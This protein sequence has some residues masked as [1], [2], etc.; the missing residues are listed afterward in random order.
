MASTTNYYA[1]KYLVSRYPEA[2]KILAEGDSWFAYPRRFIAVGSESNVIDH[3]GK[4]N[5]YVIYKTASCG[6]EALAM[7][8]GK[9]KLSLM[10]RISQTDFDFILFSGGGNDVVGRYDFDYF[11]DEK[12]QGMCAHDCISR[13]RLDR[14]LALIAA[15]YEELVDRVAV[16]SKNKSIKII[17]HTYDIAPPSEKGF[18]LFDI[19]PLGEAWMHP[20]LVSRKITDSEDQRSIVREVM[21]QFRQTLLAIQQKYPDQLCVVDTQGLLSANQWRNELHPTPDGFKLV[22]SKIAAAIDN[23]S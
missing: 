8:S 1:Y 5:K 17:T 7:M 23:L 4:Y 16:F 10:K 11:I 9:Q 18:Q 22:S 14:K 2:K 19:F 13:A 20:I 12:R 21:T 3:L 6:D 15:A